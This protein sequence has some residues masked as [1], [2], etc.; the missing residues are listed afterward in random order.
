MR[1]FNYSELQHIQII[2]EEHL[3]RKQNEF[4]PIKH[5]PESTFHAVMIREIQKTEQTLRAVNEAVSEYY[6]E[7]AR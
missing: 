3:R 5:H 4:Q 2:V 1:S 6:Q 7:K